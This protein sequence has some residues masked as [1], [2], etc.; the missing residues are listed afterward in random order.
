MSKL[1]LEELKN[2]LGTGLEVVLGKTKR[3]L[4]AVSLDSPYVFV[5]AWKGSREKQMCGLE[6]IKPIMYRLSDLDKMI[7]ELGFVPIEELKQYAPLGRNFGFAFEKD[8]LGLIG[9]R[10]PESWLD[11]VLH[12]RLFEK[13][14]EWHFWIFDQSYF[15]EGLIIDKLKQS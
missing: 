10:T 15:D 7:P 13:L 14:F 2:Y 4:T 9:Y 11:P 8:D 3:D 12:L 5:T 1:K 6:S